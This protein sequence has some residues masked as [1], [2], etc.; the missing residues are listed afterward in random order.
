[1]GS[2]AEFTINDQFSGSHQTLFLLLLIKARVPLPPELGDLLLVPLLT[3]CRGLRDHPD[4][5]T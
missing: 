5:N 3:I 4:T 2:E 1:M